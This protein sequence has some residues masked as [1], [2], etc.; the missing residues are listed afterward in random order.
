MYACSFFSNPFLEFCFSSLAF[1]ST[2]LLHKFIQVFNTSKIPVPCFGTKILWKR[3][4]ARAFC[5]HFSFCYAIFVWIWTYKTHDLTDYQLTN[6]TIGSFLQATT[7]MWSDWQIPGW[8]QFF[9]QQ[10]FPSVPSLVHFNSAIVFQSFHLDFLC[11]D[12]AAPITSYCLFSNFHC[13]CL[14]SILGIAVLLPPLLVSIAQLFLKA[15]SLSFCVQ[16]LPLHML[17]INGSFVLE[18]LVCTQNSR[19]KDAKQVRKPTFPHWISGCVGSLEKSEH[20]NL[21]ASEGE[22]RISCYELQ[23]LTGIQSH[24]AVR[25]PLPLPQICFLQ[26]P[27]QIHMDSAWKGPCCFT[28]LKAAEFPMA[29]QKSVCI[30]GITFLFS[31]KYICFM[32]LNPVLD[33]FPLQHSCCYPFSPL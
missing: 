32:Q 19:Q 6:V 2:I 12:L 20:R 10:V 4:F 21:C 27:L 14:W 25:W 22:P 15:S 9:Q 1:S 3:W 7:L 16:I 24:L 30:C 17:R 29:Q 23:W 26:F 13:V 8:P 5:K 18:T 33:L 31:V 11:D 28:Y